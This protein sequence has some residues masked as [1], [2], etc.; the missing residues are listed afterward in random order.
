MGAEEEVQ[1]TLSGG[2]PWGFRLQGG[3]EQ[4]KPLQV[5]KIRRRSQAGRAGLREQDQ[6]LSINGAACTGLSHA[7]A[8][9]LIDASGTQLIL[10]V[11]R[12]GDVGPVR[13][14]SPGELRVLS[15]SSPLSPEPPGAAAPQPLQ[16]GN[17]QSP[18]DSEAYYGETDSDMDGSATQEKPRRPRRRGPTRPSP[19]GAPPE[20]VSLSDSPAEP[21]PAS[22]ESPALGGSRVSSPSWEEGTSLQ[23]PPAEAL[24]LP[25]GPLR[26]GPHL[27]P[28][29]G[30]VPHPVA[31]DLTTSYTQKAKQAKLQRTESVQEKSIKEAKTKC[32]TIA[33]LLTAAPNPHSKGVLMFKKR[34][35]R[36]KKYTLVS[37]G[38]AVG[39]RAG[40]AG[41]EEEEDGIPPTSES[42]LEEETFSDA[43]SLTNQSDWD[44]PYL[45]MELARSGS[46]TA[47]GQGPGPGGGL[48]EAS[49]RGARLFEQ[50]RQRA[51]SSS[52]ER[53]N[54]IPPSLMNGRGPPP[55]RPQSTPPEVALL[56]PSPGLPPATSPIPLAPG[57]GAPLPGSG[58]FNRSARPFTPGF[59]GQRPVTTS[60]VFRPQAPKKANES[61]VS[62]SPFLP[63]FLS[64]PQ[65]PTL[66]PSFSIP[67]D[68][69]TLPVSIS[70]NAP[71]SSGPVTATTSLYI[72]APNRPI[73]P[74]GA[75]DSQASHGTAAMTSTASI[76]L[77]SPLRSTGLSM[78]SNP[79]N[80][81]PEAP[82][83]REQR[84]SVPAPRTGI[85]Q[86]A[87]RRGAR[88][89]MFRGGNE[90]KKNSPNPELLSLVQN[91]DEKPRAGGTESGPEEDALS[92]GAEAC[93]F[94]Q[95]SGGRSFK[96]PPLVI[97]KTPPPVTPK[98]P[99]PVAP[100][101]PPPVAP[102][103]APKGLPD[104][105]VN[106]AVPSA[107]VLP[108]PPRLQ[109]RGGELFAKRQ[110]RVDR[111]I[112][113]TTP[114]PGPDPG[115][116]FSSRP[117]S[118]SPTPSLPPSWKYS[119][120]IRA[121]PPIAYNPLLSPFF[122]LAA[123]TLPSRMQ[124]QGPRTTTKPG[125]KAIDF[126]RHQ[127]YQLK[128]AMFCFDEIPPTPS[129]IPS[130]SPKTTRV[131]E[132]RRFSTPAPQSTSEPLAPTVLTPRASTSL[133]EPIWRVEIPPTPIH[134]PSPAPTLE[135]PRGLGTSPSSCSFQ[136]ARPRF[137]AASSG[138][139]AHVWRPG[140]SHQ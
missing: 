94:M 12:V 39:E 64:P 21:A 61:L 116:I 16:P 60:V 53:P 55:S 107:G 109:G 49:G 35:Q 102:K 59:Q 19:P 95:P 139:Q 65:G 106:G 89:Q 136:V 1:V 138:L 93:N 71:C 84:I 79:S 114:G 11:R 124:P 7:S 28:M 22:L 103:P 34:R 110:S 131:H 58:I 13:S 104:G 50:Q 73:T 121:P 125:I 80:P 15:P 38:A 97:P 48:S 137:S 33:S 92:L 18:P 3:A 100:K 70:T 87:R 41:E 113:G 51:A 23:P 105:L 101:T 132:I 24:L 122:P 115:P 26:P 74:G 133:D 56:P 78:A 86:E 81:A 27:I 126:M 32:R 96:T 29:V 67:K 112:V 88:K 66:A 128:A 140:A 10:T 30:P 63:P 98:T 99:P 5:S 129:P 82:S 6:L 130:G 47:E 62:P 75:P 119:P 111:Y 85:L 8:M 36:A 20:E 135:S 46:G 25:H 37:F 127:P 118:P 40:G 68:P 31:E 134:A 42:E 44:S 52:L 14:P 45:D 43:R 54:D 77:S 123:R 4:K 120:N 2:A 57:G 90:E 69:G 108:E 9:N 117:R 83:S 17:L 76:F 91:L 72:P